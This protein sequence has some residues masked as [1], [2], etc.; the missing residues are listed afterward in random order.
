MESSDSLAEKRQQVKDR[1]ALLTASQR[2]ATNKGKK[3]K[4]QFLFMA[5]LFMILCGWGIASKELLLVLV[6]GIGL[7]VA[8]LFYIKSKSTVS[9]EVLQTEI[10][11]LQEQKMELEKKWQ[12]PVEHVALLKQKLE[13][14]SL[15]REQSVSRKSES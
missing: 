1:L 4:W 3:E 11:N 12:Q 9:D 10:K 5:M 6:G 8:I 13:K 14:D 15:L 2:H 7:L